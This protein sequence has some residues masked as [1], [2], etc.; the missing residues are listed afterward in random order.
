MFF[1]I[2]LSENCLNLSRQDFLLSSCGNLS[3]LLECS[4][5]SMTSILR[6]P[7]HDYTRKL[8]RSSDLQAFRMFPRSSNLQAFRML[9][10]SMLA[11]LAASVESWTS[12]GSVLLSI[13]NSVSSNSDLQLISAFLLCCLGWCTWKEWCKSMPNIEIDLL[14]P[15]ASMSFNMS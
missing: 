3:L 5:I 4:S 2:K 10:S 8:P 11:C 12:L 7:G 15:L 9:L 13:K 14:Y 6:S 1:E